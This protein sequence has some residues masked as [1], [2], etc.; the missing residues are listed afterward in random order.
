MGNMARDLFQSLLHLHPPLSLHDYST[1]PLPTWY[2]LLVR[3]S[4][5]VL[6]DCL[7]PES[8]CLR[9]VSTACKNFIPG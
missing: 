5:F 3:V 9:S 2:S 7:L 6:L 4:Y 8:R 1:A